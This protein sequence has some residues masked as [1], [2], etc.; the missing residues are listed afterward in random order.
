MPQ[1][2]VL[3]KEKFKDA[4][5][6]IKLLLSP[7]HQVLLHLSPAENTCPSVCNTLQAGAVEEF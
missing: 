5:K 1:T 3:W 7:S 6:P 4:N 2:H